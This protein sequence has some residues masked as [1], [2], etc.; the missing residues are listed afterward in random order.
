[1]HYRR[2]KTPGATYFFTVVTYRRRPI[3]CE[4]DTIALLREAFNTVKQQHPLVMDA[5]V[6]LPDHLHGLWTLP[7]DDTDYSTRWMLI[8]SYFTRRCPPAFK[9]ARSEALRHKR[10]PT[11]WQHRYWEHQ[12]RDE[13]DFER[14]CDYIH[15]NPVKH[16]QVVRVVEW[17]Y[18]SFHRLVREGVYPLDWAG[19]PE[20]VAA[21]GFG[22]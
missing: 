7:A 22:E 20:L 1:M 10:E 15:Y 9:T 17:P 16:D 19:V 4:P 18:S 12:I 13:R 2:S 6:I 8:K 14:H 5:I 21:S 3:L 11:V